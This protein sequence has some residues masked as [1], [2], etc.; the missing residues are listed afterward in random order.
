[1]K[2]PRDLAAKARKLFDDNEQIPFAEIVT[3][4]SLLVSI[5][6]HF[7]TVDVLNLL[8][9]CRDDTHFYAHVIHNVKT[10]LAEYLCAS[11]SETSQDKL[12]SF[13]SSLKHARSAHEKLELAAR[14]S[15]TIEVI[16]S[17]FGNDLRFVSAIG[18]LTEGYQPFDE[19]FGATITRL[20]NLTVLQQVLA[21]LA[22][23][24]VGKDTGR[25]KA[26]AGPTIDE[27][28]SRVG[29]KLPDDLYS[30]ASGNSPCGELLNKLC[31]FIRTEIDSL[32]KPAP[33]LVNRLKQDGRRRARNMATRWVYERDLNKATLL[34][35]DLT[36]LRKLPA[37]RE[38][39]LDRFYSI[40]ERNC[41]ARGGEKLYGGLGGNDEFTIGFVEPETAIECAKDIKK[42]FAEDLFF[43][44][45]GDVKFGVSVTMLAS[46][47]KEK[48]IVDCWGNAKDCC[49]FKGKDFRNRGD[50][51]V[52]RTTLNILAAIPSGSWVERFEPVSESL[53]EGE[54]LFRFKDIAPL[55]QPG[56]G[57]D[58]SSD[59][60]PGYGSPT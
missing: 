57:A 1:V 36:G 26:L 35:I 19:A 24:A 32:P 48:G 27:A 17:R 6:S 43:H 33:L 16:K 59:Q 45:K 31:Q 2:R 10:S 49:V 53:R 29:V 39:A 55:K 40:V 47:E 7:K 52:S 8:S 30:I 20:R 22:L 58:T 34:F 21:N 44:A 18:K 3:Y 38:E 46:S 54:E 51:V 42:D 23:L 13:R 9:I 41:T 14:A 37:P 12:K 56:V 60:F 11:D 50:L 5:Y 25:I 15:S 28:M 4:F